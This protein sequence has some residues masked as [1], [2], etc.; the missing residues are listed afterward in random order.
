MALK[1]ILMSYFSD[2]FYSPSVGD[3]NRAQVQEAFRITVTTA[4]S[5]AVLQTYTTPLIQLGMVKW[6]IWNKNKHCLYTADMKLDLKEN[7]L[8]LS[9][10]YEVI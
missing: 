9:V 7:E 8:I 5:L 6:T 2:P 1:H 4:R 10:P 3:Q